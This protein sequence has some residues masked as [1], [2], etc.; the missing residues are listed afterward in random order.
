[1]EILKQY[2]NSNIY[3]SHFIGSEVDVVILG[4]ANGMGL[5]GHNDGPFAFFFLSQLDEKH[6]FC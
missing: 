3:F 5:Q 4:N 6:S 2:Y 1:M